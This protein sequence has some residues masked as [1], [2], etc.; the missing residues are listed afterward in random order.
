MHTAVAIITVSTKYCCSFLCWMFFSVALIIAFCFTTKQRQVSPIIFLPLFLVGLFFH[1]FLSFCIAIAHKNTTILIKKTSK[2]K[3]KNQLLNIAMKER[4]LTIAW[5]SL[6]ASHSF[7][8]FIIEYLLYLRFSTLT[9][10]DGKLNRFY[11]MCIALSLFFV[12]VKSPI[13]K[14]RQLL[15]IQYIQLDLI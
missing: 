12:C 8:K 11:K 4:Q 1:P 6:I 7:K 15:D 13:G 10:Q 2:P 9:F 3:K 5:D 14:D